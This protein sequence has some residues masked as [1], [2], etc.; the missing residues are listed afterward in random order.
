MKKIVVFNGSPRKNGYTSKLLAKV[1]EGAKSEGAS[2]IE[3]DLNDPGVRGCQSCFYCRQHDGCSVKDYL[4]PM[5]D[6]I[7]EADG[8]VF[9]SP[10]YYYQITGQARLWLDRTFPMIGEGFS[11]RHSGKKAVTIFTQGSPDPKVGQ[12]AISFI[13]QILHKTYGWTIEETIHCCGTTNSIPANFE[14]LSERSF[15]AGQALC[16]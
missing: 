12:D 11:P 16:R 1:I 13:D 5:Y 15:K 14:E 2:V 8:I 10:I 3:F 7:R 4:A 6:A 9:G